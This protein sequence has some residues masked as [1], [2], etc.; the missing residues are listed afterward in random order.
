MAPFHRT[1]GIRTSPQLS[2]ST[3][4]VTLCGFLSRLDAS[5]LTRCR[6]LFDFSVEFTAEQE[7]HAAPIEPE[8]QYNDAGDRPIHLVVIAEVVHVGFEAQRHDHPHKDGEYRSR[9]YP[10]PLLFDV[11]THEIDG[12]DDQEHEG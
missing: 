6:S 9:G 4:T 5:L 2:I 7:H 10:A 11:W 12:V 8:H 3:K 1:R